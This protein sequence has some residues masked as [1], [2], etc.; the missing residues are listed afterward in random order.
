MMCH[1]LVEK[2]KKKGCAIEMKHCF[3]CGTKLEMKELEGEGMVPFCPHCNT[4]RFPMFNVAVSAEIL[5]PEKN[6]ITIVIIVAIII[7]SFFLIF[8]FFLVFIFY[9]PS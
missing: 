6:N 8:I 3:E 5:N 2:V 1:Y 9:I 7:N 4:F